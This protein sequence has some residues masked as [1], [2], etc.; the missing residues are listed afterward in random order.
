MLPILFGRYDHLHSLILG[1]IDDGIAIITT[2]G[3]KMLSLYSF[4]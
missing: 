2:V 3:E 4:Q 1:L